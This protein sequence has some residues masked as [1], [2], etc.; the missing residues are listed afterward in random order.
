MAEPAYS[1]ASAI[2]VIDAR[3][4]A[5]SA[6]NRGQAL[7]T[8][9]DA[10][11]RW[12]FFQLIGHGVPEAER[13]D[14]FRAEAD[15][16]ALPEADKLA[17]S[18]CADNPR[19]Y[20][21]GEFTKN[22]RDAKEILDFGHKPDPDAADDTPVNRTP[23]GWNRFPDPATLPG[24]APAV[25]NWYRRCE[26][27]SS[28]LL[29]AFAESLERPSAELEECF[30]VEH[31]SFLRLNR[32][33]P[34]PDPAPADAPDLPESGRLGIYHH[35]D[36]GVLTLLVQEGSAALQVRHAGRWHLIEPLDD[37]FI[38]NVG[39][40]MQV[41]TNDAFIAPEHR[42]LATPADGHRMSAAFFFNP[43]WDA[44]IEPL[45]GVTAEAPPAY[46]P[47][48]WGEFRRQR[49]DGD[50]ADL[51]EEVQISRYRWQVSPG[52]PGTH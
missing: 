18:R 50:Y 42:V 43:A 37:A 26:E 49:A 11:A 10:A 38:V 13:R 17:L 30:G 29:R 40:M 31:T 25:W 24:F 47:F 1:L 21:P 44:R 7:E 51:G 34:Q 33:P 45:A 35:T 12:G 6:P 39:D 5:P 19:G 14:L 46:R 16:F 4:L 41:A 36:A 3:D 9:R 52:T 20:N 22:R 28:L 48:T 32:Y 23:D 2:P 27:L 15:F 8:L